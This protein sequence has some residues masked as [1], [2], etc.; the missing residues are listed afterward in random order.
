MDSSALQMNGVIK[1]QETITIHSK[2]E[3]G[4]DR[5][6]EDDDD[7]VETTFD[8]DTVDFEQSAKDKRD[9]IVDG[10]WAFFV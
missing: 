9:T 6:A 1:H 5:K 8:M 7:V 2:R 4:S 3:N 10:K